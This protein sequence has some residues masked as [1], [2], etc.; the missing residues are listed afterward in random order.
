MPVNKTKKA[1][2]KRATNSRGALVG[3]IK[4]HSAKKLTFFSVLASI[5]LVALGYG[6]YYAWQQRNHKSLANSFKANAANY[7]AVIGAK[8]GYFI[9]MAC[10]KQYSSSKPD[11]VWVLIGR[12][13]NEQNQYDAQIWAIRTAKSTQMKAIASNGQDLFV[14][15][16]A[17][18]WANTLQKYVMPIGRA[19][20]NA[21]AYLSGSV[22]MEAS[23][24]VITDSLTSAYT[25]PRTNGSTGYPLIRNLPVC[26]Y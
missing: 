9:A 26:S 20:I 4:A 18:W 7:G 14:Q 16:S 11:E 23:R 22:E 21:G 3:G 1:P 17:S 10:Q 25:G 6:G 15:S 12:Q 13:V 2:A 19:N 24:V 5:V 8:N